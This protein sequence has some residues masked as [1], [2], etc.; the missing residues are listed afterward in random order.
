MP[1]SSDKEMVLIV[2]GFFV[3]WLSL[4]IIATEKEIVF[5]VYFVV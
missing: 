4:F 5:N 3:I 2:L 1:S